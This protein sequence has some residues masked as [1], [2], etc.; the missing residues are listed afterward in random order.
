[1]L[2]DIHSALGCCRARG[3]QH[4]FSLISSCGVQEHLQ[5]LEVAPC[6]RTFVRVLNS[7]R[8]VLQPAYC[9]S[10]LRCARPQSLPG[11]RPCFAHPD[12][13]LHPATPSAAPGRPENVETA[14]RNPP[15]VPP[16]RCS[17]C[18]RGCL[19]TDESS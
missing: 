8:A 2:Q 16:C 10:G 17:G 9:V 14:A 15:A 4:S 18:V 12:W 3:D 7:R 1:M 5:S 13:P 11:I 6:L 19:K